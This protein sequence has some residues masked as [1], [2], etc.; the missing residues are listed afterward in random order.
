MIK[1]IKNK[2]Y[3]KLLSHNVMVSCFIGYLVIN[4]MVIYDFII[5]KEKF[6]FQNWG[7]LIIFPIFIFVTSHIEYL[8]KQKEDEPTIIILKKSKNKNSYFYGCKCGYK[9][10]YKNR[11][12]LK[13]KW[14]SFWKNYYS[15]KVKIHHDKMIK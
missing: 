11:Y 3:W 13:F 7:W 15:K 4:L 14:H 6:N 5:G 8:F 1:F 2:K 9:Y 12:S 10:V